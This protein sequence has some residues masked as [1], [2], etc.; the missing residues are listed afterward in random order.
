MKVS[1]YQINSVIKTYIKNNKDRL[2]GITQ[3]AEGHNGPEDDVNISDAGKRILYERMRN[4][5]M[6]RA[7]KENGLN[8][9]E[10]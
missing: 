7:H 3:A 6:D 10:A 9:Q 2:S 5:V 8:E 4:Q 1:E